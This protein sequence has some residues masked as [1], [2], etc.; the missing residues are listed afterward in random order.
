[1]PHDEVSRTV[2]AVHGARCINPDPV[3]VGSLAKE[4]IAHYERDAL[5]ELYGRFV[6]GEGFLDGLM[7]K[8]IW[9][10]L[11]RSCGVGLTVEAGARFKHPDTFVIGDGVFVGSQVYLQGRYDGSCIIGNK[12]WIGPQ[13]YFDAR[14]LILEDHVGWGPGARVLGSAHTGVPSDIPII[15]TDLIIKPVRVCQWADIGT[16]AILLPGVTVGEGAI[17]GAGAVVRVD[18]PPFAKVAGV[19]AE[20]IGWRDKVESKRGA[21]E[22]Y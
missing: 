3:Y 4:L 16:G 14:N 5:T 12:V 2:A 9:R 11:S 21:N 15:E 6:Q 8:I 17:V 13:S 22:D 18:V 19:P 1:M 7:R 10:A 20:I